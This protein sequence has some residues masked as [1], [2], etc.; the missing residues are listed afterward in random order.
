MCAR[1]C[2]RAESG[3]ELNKERDEEGRYVS[4]C[5]ALL[6]T[7]SWDRVQRPQ[8]KGWRCSRDERIQQPTCIFVEKLVDQSTIFR[9]AFLSNE[10]SPHG[11]MNR[12][13]CVG[14]F[15]RVSARAHIGGAFPRSCVPQSQAYVSVDQPA[16]QVLPTLIEGKLSPRD[17]SISDRAQEPVHGLKF[18]K[19]LK[20]SVPVGLLPQQ[21]MK[22][23]W[24]G[25]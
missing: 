11:W 25:T 16:V 10:R 15:P 9:L 24:R 20:Q 4:L 3:I 1:V 5:S 14:F 18:G 22:P 12:E 23:L 6:A 13:F 19:I 8:R 17:W 21:A 2:P 7:L